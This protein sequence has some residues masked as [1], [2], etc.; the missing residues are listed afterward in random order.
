MGI[1]KRNGNWSRTV[2]ENGPK[3]SEGLAKNTV[4]G[5]VVSIHLFKILVASELRR[6]HQANEVSVSTMCSMERN[7]FQTTSGKTRLKT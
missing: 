6:H 4:S 3:A 7:R 5:T 1:H 2:W